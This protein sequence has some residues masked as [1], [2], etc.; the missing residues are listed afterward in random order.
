MISTVRPVAQRLLMRRVMMMRSLLALTLFATACTSPSPSA[1]ESYDSVR[2]RLSSGP[3]RLFM[4]GG[5]S[6]GVVTARR[7]TSGGWIEGD[8]PLVIGGAELSATVD[9][10]GQLTLTS[11]EVD[12][13]PI[14][15]P[16]DVF[17]KPAELSDVRIKLTAPAR[18]AATW[19]TD[20]TAT[21]T[22]G[23]ALDLDWS[24]T[25]NGGK[26]PLGSQHLPPIDVNLTLGGDAD[27]VEANIALAAS[28]ELWNWA[29]LLKL[30]H[31]ELAVAATTVD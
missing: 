3:T 30:S 13:A 6:S 31:L 17:K 21:V 20:D 18:A 23:V 5:E 12:V 8:T 15:I 9:A 19:S 22:L 2:D 16:E 7:W 27:V 28:G 26:T 14:E 11:F 1:G 10:N 25:V 24:I 4:G 29:G